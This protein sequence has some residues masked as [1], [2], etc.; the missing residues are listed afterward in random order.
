MSWLNKAFGA[1]KKQGGGGGGMAGPQDTKARDGLAE[2]IEIMEKKME[3]LDNLGRAEQKKAKAFG[4]KTAANKAKAVVCLKRYK[5]YQKQ[6]A[7]ISGQRD[8]LDAQ[9]SALEMSMLAAANIAAMEQAAKTIGN[10]IDLDRAEDTLDEIKDQMDQVTD[11]TNLLSEP[12]AG[13]E[14]YDEEDLEGEL[15]EWLVEDEVGVDDLT[16][17]LTGDLPDVETVAPM[18]DVPTTTPKM[19]EEAAQL[20]ELNAWMD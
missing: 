20:A 11:I 3:H 13:G 6:A 2:Q 8:N 12:M 1:P 9:K 4:N 18:P 15:D 16:D 10:N 7:Q 19:T 17:Q 14:V 5:N